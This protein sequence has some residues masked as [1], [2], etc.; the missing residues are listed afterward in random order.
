MTVVFKERKVV[1]WRVILLNVPVQMGFFTY[2]DRT[3]LAF[4]AFQFKADL[5][6]S[7]S[8][9]GLGNPQHRLS[10][11]RPAQPVELLYP[12]SA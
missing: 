9:Y 8:I 2:L 12:A 3:N 6:L 7:N 10:R 5:H 1:D 4:A 11:G